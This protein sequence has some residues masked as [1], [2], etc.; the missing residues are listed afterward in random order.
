MVWELHEAKSESEEAFRSGLNC[1]ESMLTTSIKLLDLDLPKE[2]VHMGRFFRRGIGETGCICGAMVGGVMM[3]SYLMHDHPKGLE[4][5]QH[6]ETAFKQRH[7]ATC[8]RVI[9]KS[10]NV[11]SRL[12]NKECEKLTGDTAF[13][14]FQILQ[15]YQLPL[16][17]VTQ[18]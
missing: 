13:L 17:K 18:S 5:V 15:S 11:L 4:A 1:C 2:V 7:K 6:F 14:L 10:Q 9:R 8:C 3:L 16:K 12:T